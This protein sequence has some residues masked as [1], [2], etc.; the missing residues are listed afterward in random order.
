M[1]EEQFDKGYW[2]AVEIKAF[3]REIGIRSTSKLRKDEL[4]E[5]IRHYLRSGELGQAKR[6][7][8]A[9][10]GVRDYEI[11]LSLELPVV[12]YT[13]NK[14]TKEFIRSEAL[15]INPNLKRKSGVLYRL[16]RWREEQIAEGKSINYGDIVDQYISLS[17]VVGNFPQAPS[18]RYI[19]FVS[20]FL[21]GEKNAGREEALQAW[22]ELKRLDIV[23]SYRA[24]KEY[25]K[26]QRR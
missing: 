13:D 23:K 4:E 1:T 26:A 10:S 19:N 15:K 12:R 18:G 17:Q 2:Y 20:D 7:V 25:H 6:K 16:N 24:W 22:E 9:R 3:A 14:A 5:L 11:G 8:S 21:A